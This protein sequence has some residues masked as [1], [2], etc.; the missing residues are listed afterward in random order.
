MVAEPLLWI[1]PNGVSPTSPEPPR[2]QFVLRS[3]AFAS[4]ARLEVRQNGR[5]LKAAHARLVPGRSIRLD[6]GW[7]RRVDP[8][9]GPVLVTAQ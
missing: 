9:G 1:S 8:A 2:G 6:G 5:L 3:A 7:A 4:R